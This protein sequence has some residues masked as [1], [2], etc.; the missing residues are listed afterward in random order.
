[1]NFSTEF[2][3]DW[4]ESVFENVNLIFGVH[5]GGRAQGNR[6]PAQADVTVWACEDFSMHNKGTA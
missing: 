3:S 2:G 1:M 4:Y 6:S 5:L